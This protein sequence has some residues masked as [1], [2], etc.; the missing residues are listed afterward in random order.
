MFTVTDKKLVFAV[1]LFTAENNSF[2]KFIFKNFI[3]NY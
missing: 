1:R 2:S 3:S